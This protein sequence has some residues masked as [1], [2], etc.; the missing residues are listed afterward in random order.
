MADERAAALTGSTG[1][2][3]RGLR[4]ALLLTPALVVVAVFFSAGVV[5]TLAQSFGYQPYLPGS[6]L[7]LDAYRALAG[8]PAVRASLLLTA[9]I[10]LVS[11]VSAAALGVVAALGIRRVGRGQRWVTGAFTANLA[12]PHLVGALCMLLLLGQ[13]GFVSRLTHAVGLT[14]DPSS[15]PALTNDAFGVGIIAEYVWKEAPFLTVLALAA[16]NRGADEL[17][18]AARTLGAGRAQRL[19]HVTLPL[20]APAVGAGSVLVLAFTAGSYEVPFLLGQPYPTTLPVVAL[21]FYRDTDLGMR[22]VAMAVAVLIT[23]ST[24]AVVA[25]YLRLVSRLGRR[26][27]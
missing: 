4:I 18:D 2:L 20:L 7:S 8:D 12:V 23:V 16:L 24:S 9:R 26:S 19:R 5:Q 13:T 10:A 11:T 1:P 3:P 25:V 6:R 17:A 22:P 14:G 21:S 27:V 15:F